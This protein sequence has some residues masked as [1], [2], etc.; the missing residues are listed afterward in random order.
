MPNPLP[1]LG[2]D[3]RSIA[4]TILCDASGA[5]PT[6]DVKRAVQLIERHVAARTAELQAHLAYA[7]SRKE[8]W[9]ASTK[10]LE[11]RTG[12]LESLI[13]QLR[14]CLQSQ[15]ARLKEVGRSTK[16]ADLMIEKA[17]AALVANNEG[18]E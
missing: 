10:E 1:V 6:E 16:E 18:R 3:A 17:R 9:R 12:K 13:V 11:A 8:H 15:A 2:S 5:C 4:E 7:K 14:D